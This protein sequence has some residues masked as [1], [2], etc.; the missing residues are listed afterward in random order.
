MPPL[1]FFFLRLFNFGSLRF[2]L[3]DITGEKKG[4]IKMLSAVVGK[5]LELS[6]PEMS[7]ATQRR[8][9]EVYRRMKQEGLEVIEESVRA[10]VYYKGY[11]EPG[12]SIASRHETFRAAVFIT[13]ERLLVLRQSSYEHVIDMP[14]SAP[15]LSSLIVEIDGRALRVAATDV[16]L[17]HSRKTGAMDVLLSVAHPLYLRRVILSHFPDTQPGLLP[18]FSNYVPRSSRPRGHAHYERHR[19][20]SAVDSYSDRRRHSHAYNYNRRFT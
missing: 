13:K 2:T 16:S 5:L 19:R 6:N 9:S 8:R 15:A 18:S 7:G 14:W 4:G 20:Y 3:P 12:R 1:V 17:F 11:S 10:R